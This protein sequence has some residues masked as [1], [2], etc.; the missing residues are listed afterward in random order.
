MNCI[1]LKS[2]S[3]LFDI[4]VIDSKRWYS[5][6]TV[7]NLKMSTQAKAIAQTDHGEPSNLSSKDNHLVLPIFFEGVDYGLAHAT[8]SSDD[9]NDDH[10]EGL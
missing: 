8:G 10:C 4:V 5:N 7:G 3:D 6:F 1:L 2:L 9:C